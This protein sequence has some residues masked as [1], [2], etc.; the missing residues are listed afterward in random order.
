M[1]GFWDWQRD[2][3]PSRVLA[4]LLAVGVAWW[5][6]FHVLFPL[7]LDP[8]RPRPPWPRDAFGRALAL[9]WLLACGAVLVFFA[10]R[11]GQLLDAGAVAAAGVL[12]AVL[13]LLLVRH[14]DPRPTAGPQSKG[15]DP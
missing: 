3:S 4:T 15:T 6:C 11:S 1:P 10:A 7:W 2:W 13:I 12:G 5:L 14:R 8:R 9:F